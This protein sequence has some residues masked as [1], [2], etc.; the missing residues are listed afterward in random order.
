MK[1]MVTGPRGQ[2]IEAT[3]VDNDDGSYDFEYKVLGTGDYTVIITCDSAPV[4][5]SPYVKS[6][7]IP[8]ERKSRPLS[9]GFGKK[10]FT[11][12]KK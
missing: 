8:K 11:F 1:A 5:N 2:V 6:Y 9:V 3:C 4:A 10:G 12:S 7:F